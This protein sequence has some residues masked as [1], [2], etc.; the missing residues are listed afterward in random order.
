M[1]KHLN[2]STWAVFAFEASS[3]WPLEIGRRLD[4]WTSLDFSEAH[5]E[6]PLIVLSRLRKTFDTGNH[7]DVDIQVMAVHVYSRWDVFALTVCVRC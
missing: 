1:V 2:R 5:D 6:D 3:D 7:V 4:F